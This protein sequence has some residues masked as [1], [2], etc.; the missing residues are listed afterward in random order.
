MTIRALDP[1]FFRCEIQQ[2]GDTPVNTSGVRLEAKDLLT[3]FSGMPHGTLPDK[4]TYTVGFIDSSD[5]ILWSMVC[6]FNS[7]FSG[8][9]VR[10]RTWPD[11]GRPVFYKSDLVRKISDEK[12]GVSWEEAFVYAHNELERELFEQFP[13]MNLL[14]KDW[15]DGG[16]MPLIRSQI[17]A[18]QQR[19]RMRPAKGFA[20]KPGR[21]P[22]HLWGDQLRDRSGTG[23]IERRTEQPN[24]I[25]FDA[26]IIKSMA[27]RRLLTAVGAPSAVMLPGV[28]ER[29]NRLLVEHFTA[30]RPIEV[31]YDGSTA[32]RWNQIPFRDNDWWDCFCGCVTAAASLGC[33]LPGDNPTQ[34]KVRTFTLPGG[35]R[36]A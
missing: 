15:S 24:H 2:E 20:P 31:T 23:W 1:G 35:V 7:D 25:Q 14:L 19:S 28:N 9:I 10:Y 3:R 29:E 5:Q 32:V 33:K 27:A 6:A 22:I 36:N 26:N 16:H 18:S 11:Q 4:S 8:Y 30:E 34:K 21:K 13:D 12:P 17:A